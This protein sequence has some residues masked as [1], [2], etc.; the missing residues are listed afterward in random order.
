HERVAQRGDVRTDL[1]EVDVGP[2]VHAD[3][4]EQDREESVEQVRGVLGVDRDGLA[5]Q[6]A[7]A[8]DSGCREELEA[9]GM[10]PREREVWLAY[11]DIRGDVASVF[12]ALFG[13]SLVQSLLVAFLVAHVLDSCR[14]LLE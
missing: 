8:G 13:L 4:R 14:T 5:A 3:V 1:D 2:R 9:A 10:H 11:I 7:D 6:V 12:A